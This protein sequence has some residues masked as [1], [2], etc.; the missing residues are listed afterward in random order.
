MINR[1]L[2]YIFWILVWGTIVLATFTQILS[3]H[4]CTTFDNGLLKGVKGTCHPNTRHPYLSS[5]KCVHIPEFT[6]LPG[7]H[8]L[9]FE[10]IR[11]YIWNFQVRP[12]TPSQ[13]RYVLRLRLRQYLAGSEHI[14]HV[15]RAYILLFSKQE[16]TRIKD[17][18]NTEKNNNFF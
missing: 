15:Y 3:F 11:L 7:F 4:P 16:L 5:K 6:V 14:N 1:N 17:S 8:F 2:L 12:I 9:L 10:K 13:L 18:Q